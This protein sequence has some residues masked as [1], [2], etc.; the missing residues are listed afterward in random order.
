MLKIS[1]KC[2]DWSSKWISG[3]NDNKTNWKPSFI[4]K[5]PIML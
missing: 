3:I 4:K 5:K 1:S 2:S